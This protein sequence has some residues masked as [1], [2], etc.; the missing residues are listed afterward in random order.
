M[1]GT[2]ARELLAAPIPGKLA[3]LEMLI[4]YSAL[5]PPHVPQ[6]SWGSIDVDGA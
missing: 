4:G 1:N 2:V 3:L 5:R 6:P